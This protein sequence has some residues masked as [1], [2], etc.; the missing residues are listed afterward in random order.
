MF[1]NCYPTPLHNIES[2]V[3]QGSS[4]VCEVTSDPKPFFALFINAILIATLVCTFLICA[5][6]L[7]LSSIVNPKNVIEL[8]SNFKH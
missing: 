1:C 7:I 8:K 5:F 2:M 4:K 6:Q 3:R